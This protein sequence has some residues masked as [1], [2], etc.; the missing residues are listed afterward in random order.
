MTAKVL[1]DSKKMRYTVV[2]VDEVL[3]GNAVRAE[4]AETFVRTSVPAIWIKRITGTISP[5]E[6][7]D[8]IY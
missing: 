5:H 8:K 7:F 2:E 6:Y 1:L 3:D 4:I